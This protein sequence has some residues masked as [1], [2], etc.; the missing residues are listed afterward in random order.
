LTRF[1]LGLYS[2]VRIREVPPETETVALPSLKQLTLFELEVIE[3]N[4]LMAVLLAPI[5]L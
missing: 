1:E 5:A 4:A 3:L 2:R